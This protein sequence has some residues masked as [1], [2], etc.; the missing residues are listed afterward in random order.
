MQL[1]MKE[2]MEGTKSCFFFSLQ[3]AMTIAPVL[4][5][6]GPLEDLSFKPNPAEVLYSAFFNTLHM[7]WTCEQFEG[8]VSY[9]CFYTR[10]LFP[11]AALKPSQP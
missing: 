3:S 6:L 1:K 7:V 5:N 9:I 2:S 8:S 11:V 10:L 4:A